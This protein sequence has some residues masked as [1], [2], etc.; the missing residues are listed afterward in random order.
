MT[1][2]TYA[3]Q[4][5]TAEG[6]YPFA[7]AVLCPPEELPK[8]CT[9]LKRLNELLDTSE[10]KDLYMLDTAL[11]KTMK[12]ICPQSVS[13][14]AI[15]LQAWEK[16]PV[17]GGIIGA[18]HQIY[19]SANGELEQLKDHLWCMAFPGGP[20][21]VLAGPKSLALRMMQEI[22]ISRNLQIDPWSQIKKHLWEAKA[23]LYVTDGSGAK[24]FLAAGDEKDNC[25]IHLNEE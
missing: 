14:A 24:G 23:Y 22:T 18:P 2:Y 15:T 21:L 7:A 19:R 17:S 6:K 10:F 13:A 3:I 20:G 11:A 4:T 16:G 8:V 25:I 12:I 1:K 5:G 9:E